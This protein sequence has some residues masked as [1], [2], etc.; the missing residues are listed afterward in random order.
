MRREIGD[1]IQDIIEAID[2]LM[3]HEICERHVL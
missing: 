1:Y 3:A 2:K